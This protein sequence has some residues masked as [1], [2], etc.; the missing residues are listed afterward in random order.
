MTIS[1]VVIGYEV[2]N[3]YIES[4]TLKLPQLLLTVINRRCTFLSTT[5]LA[6]D[7]RDILDVKHL[8]ELACNSKTPVKQAADSPPRSVFTP[9]SLRHLQEGK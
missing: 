1:T 6:E 3:G 5:R 9:G 2:Q 7:G 8:I 4:L